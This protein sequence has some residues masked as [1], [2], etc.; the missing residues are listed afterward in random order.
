VTNILIARRPERVLDNPSSVITYPVFQFLKRNAKIRT[1]PQD[2]D[3]ILLRN[4]T[5]SEC[6]QVVLDEHLD[7]LIL[8]AIEVSGVP[9]IDGPFCCLDPT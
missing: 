8:D 6:N 7:S 3:E 1:G 5:S 2:F 9:A 4:T